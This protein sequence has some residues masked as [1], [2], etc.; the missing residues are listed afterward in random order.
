MRC[1]W[2]RLSTTSWNVIFW[3]Q[4]ISRLRK[5]RDL[6]SNCAYSSDSS[7]SSKECNLRITL[8]KDTHHLWAERKTTLQI[9]KYVGYTKLPQWPYKI[10]IWYDHYGNCGLHTLEF[11]VNALPEKRRWT[12]A[13]TPILVYSS[14]T[15]ALTAS[16][17][18]VP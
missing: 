4:K 18:L 2:S 11:A 8:Q 16:S 10:W 6:Y 9:P 3:T 7:W 12:C 17:R 13:P 5:S 15:P 14:R 1:L